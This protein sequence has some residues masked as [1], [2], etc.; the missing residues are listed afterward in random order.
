MPNGFG[1]PIT[2][3]YLMM[4]CKFGVQFIA[5]S[6]LHSQKICVPTVTSGCWVIILCTELNTRYSF[7]NQVSRA[8]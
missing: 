2:M 5:F 1:T 8:F 3:L 6:L 7:L 4:F